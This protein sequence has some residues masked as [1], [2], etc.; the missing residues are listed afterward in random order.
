M[1][2]TFSRNIHIAA[3]ASVLGA[4]VAANADILIVSDHNAAMGPKHDAMAHCLEAVKR[5]VG[6]GQSLVFSNRVATMQT[7]Q[8][9][10]AVVV[11][12]TVWENGAR[13]PIQGR[14]ERSASGAM[15]ATVTRAQNDQAIA[16]AN[17]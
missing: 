9:A 14:C 6:E 10:R 13:V 1:N 8:G 15:V 5:Q 4:A 3:F 16:Q 12:A 7:N 17:H 2:A 11:N